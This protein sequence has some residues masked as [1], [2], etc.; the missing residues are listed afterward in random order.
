M[1]P[2]R[3]TK[4]FSECFIGCNVKQFDGASTVASL[5]HPKEGSDSH[6]AHEPVYRLPPFCDF[7]P[8]PVVN[9]KINPQRIGAQRGVYKAEALVDEM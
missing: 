6:V 8:C 5:H 2:L 1:L 3:I 4:Y 7:N 9:K